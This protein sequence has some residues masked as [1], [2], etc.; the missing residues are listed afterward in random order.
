[1][2]ILVVGSGGREHALAWVIGNCPE[3]EKLWIAP[4]NPGTAEVGTNVNIDPL[5]FEAIARLCREESIGLVAVGPEKPLSAGIAD[6]LWEKGIP[7]FGPTKAGANLEASKS[8]AK[9][10][11]ERHNIPHPQFR[12][13]ESSK[14]AVDYIQSVPGPWVIKADGLALG[15]G[16][17]ITADIN[18]AIEVINELLSGRLHGEAGKRIVIE[19][20]LEGTEAT[21]MALCDGN[22]IYPL[23]MAKDHKRVYDGD[24]GP[25]TGGMGA[26]SPLPFVSGEMEQDIFRNVLDRTLAGLKKD[27]IDYRGVIYAGLM[28]TRSGPKV[29][30]YNV[31]FG[32]PEAQCVLPRL[33]GNVSGLLMACAE[34]KLAGFLSGHEIGVKDKAASTVVMASQGYPGK[35]AKGFPIKGLDRARQVSPGNVIVFHAG[36][37]KDEDGHLVNSG[38]RVLAVTTLGSTLGE[39]RADAY[40]AVREISFSGAYYRTDIGKEF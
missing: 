18:E 20:F 10:F 39:A 26:F 13:F 24:Q 4:G 8:A 28:L 35:Y 1:M 5:D 36:T 40:R 12:V 32:D 7:T 22:C 34:G 21:A 14:E 6:F 29:L 15:K 31:R 25:M 3:V 37:G 11:M 19:E 16:V 27:G 17:I 33:S 23:P 2:R 9:E 30:E 38:G